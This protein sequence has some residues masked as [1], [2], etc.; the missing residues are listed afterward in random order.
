MNKRKMTS[1]ALV[2]AVAISTV[3]LAYPANV[4]ANEQV[5]I[6]RSQGEQV[7][8][9]GFCGGDSSYNS[10][11]YSFTNGKGELIEYTY[12]NNIKWE[13]KENG[14]V[15][16]KKKTYT[17]KIDG[18]GDMAD[19]EKSWSYGGKSWIEGVKEDNNVKITDARLYITKIEIEGKINNIG[20]DDFDGLDNIES[21]TIPEGVKTIGAYAFN[22]CTN[23]KIVNLNSDLEVLG[24]TSF[25]DCKALENIT[26]PKNL[27]EIQ[28]L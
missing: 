20:Y 12:Y 14:T 19:F 6:N 2:A 26:F 13:I 11:T 25:S 16:D 8:K 18:N 1:I 7:G 17:L 4:F 10:K 28:I 15:S 3:Q 23:L 9:V 27:K 24:E 21:V 5:N 22:H